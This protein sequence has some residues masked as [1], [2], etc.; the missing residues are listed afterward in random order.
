MGGYGNLVVVL[1]AMVGVYAI[2]FRGVRRRSGGQS[3]SPFVRYREVG[4]GDVSAQC[5]QCLP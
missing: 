2:I 3:K 1:V 4:Y 5:S